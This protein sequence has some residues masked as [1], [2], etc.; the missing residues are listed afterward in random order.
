MKTLICDISERNTVYSKGWDKTTSPIQ[1]MEKAFTENYALIVI[2]F[3]AQT[4]KQRYALIELC[5]VL[6][7]NQQTHHIPIMALLPIKHRLLLE[8]L[9]KVNVEY[10]KII[11]DQADEKDIR[12]F[13]T[14]D[15][16]SRHLSGLCPF[17]EYQAIDSSREMTVCKAYYSR[18]VITGNRLKQ[19]CHHPDFKICPYFQLPKLA[20]KMMTRNINEHFAPN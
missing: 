3:A 17:L 4:I 14:E 12:Y 9:S 1:C 7:R 16:L 5:A 19:T 2:Q 6:K 8:N 15:S 18:L 13:D 10:A 20:K 11:T